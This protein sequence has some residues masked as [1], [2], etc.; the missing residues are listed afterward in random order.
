MESIE[1]YQ[2]P[3]GGIMIHD[4]NGARQLKEHDREFIGKMIEK[5]SEFYP[6]ALADLSKLFEKKRLNIP[7]FEYRIV[8]RFIKCNWG[9]FDSAM[10]IDQFGNLN[11]EEV[12]CPLR[13]ECP[14]EGIVC[15]PKFNSNLSDREIEVMRCY[16]DGLT[17]EQIANK[18]CL[19][20][21]TVKTHKRNVF[22]RTNTHTL[23][24]FFLYAKSKNLFDY[25]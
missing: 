5:L 13:G 18:I 11:F 25:E 19:S 14:Q 2:T 12:E 20:I 4:L 8:L 7:H 3:K 23:A 9:K 16:Y 1:F 24:E 10:D 21:E 22:K 15:K 17:A 6:E